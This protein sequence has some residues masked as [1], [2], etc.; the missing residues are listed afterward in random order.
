MEKQIDRIAEMKDMR[1]FFGMEND[2]CSFTA[3]GE[4]CYKVTFLNETKITYSNM[5][6]WECNGFTLV[7]FGINTDKQ[8]T[9]KINVN[10]RRIRN[11]TVKQEFVIQ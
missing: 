8:L 3:D 9:V 11:G 10:D 1:T 6:S 5:A 2:E 4:N 7:G